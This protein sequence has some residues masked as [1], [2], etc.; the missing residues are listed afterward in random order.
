MRMQLVLQHLLAALASGANFILRNKI[1]EML[2][3][4][5][6]S[7]IVDALLAWATSESELVAC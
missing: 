4:G 7:V 3:S 6:V 1:T 2:N 5:S